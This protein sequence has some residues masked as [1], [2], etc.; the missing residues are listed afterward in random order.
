MKRIILSAALLAAIAS[1]HAQAQ[2]TTTTSITFPLTVS[3]AANCLPNAKGTV[4]DH[5]FGEFENLE[6]VVKGL[7]PNTD[8]DLFSI[9]VPN[10]PFG[11]A[12][13]IGDI[14]TD[15]TGTGVGNFVGRFNVETF[16]V[17]TGIPLAEPPQ[18]F[19]DPPAVIPE[20]TIG[21]QT[22]P[23]QLYHLGLWFN[24]PADA[25]NAGCPN[26][27]TPFNGEHNAGIQIL[28]TGTFPDTAGPLIKLK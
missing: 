1:T 13:Y 26:T 27:A 23:V 6:V 22:N 28:N 8:F 2:S 18:E 19:P 20:A 7:P 16:V 17:S 14:D 9:E 3:S 12:W 5:S 24:S 15:A 4:T 10:K 25:A 11:L 21:V